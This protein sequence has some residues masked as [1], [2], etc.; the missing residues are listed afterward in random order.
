M[1][2][3]SRGAECSMGNIFRVFRDLKWYLK[4]E[5]RGKSLPILHKATCDNYF[6]LKCFLKPNIARVFSLHTKQVYRGNSNLRILTGKNYFNQFI[7]TRMAAWLQ[8]RCLKN[9]SHQIGSKNEWLLL[10]ASLP[11]NLGCFLS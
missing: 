2:L 6:I 10:L 7:S 4:Y 11:Q 8:Y 1:Q 5:E 3:L 9:V